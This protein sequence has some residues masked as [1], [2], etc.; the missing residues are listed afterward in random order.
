MSFPD[1]V[2]QTEWRQSPPYQWWRRHDEYDFLADEAA[3]P[4][5]RR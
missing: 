4:G 2:S 1:V 3:V 5:A